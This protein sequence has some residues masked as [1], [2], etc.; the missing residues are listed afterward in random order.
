[1]KM[2]TQVCCV[3]I[4]LYS[5]V[6]S[7][8]ASKAI[9]QIRS[10]GAKQMK[11]KDIHALFSGSKVN[12]IGYG[13]D[14][15]LIFHLNGALSAENERGEKNDGVWGIDGHDN[16]CLKFKRWGG[17]DKICY[18][19]FVLDNEYKFFSNNIKRY[20]AKILSQNFEGA[21]V[22]VNKPVSAGHLQLPYPEDSLPAPGNVQE[23]KTTRAELTPQSK[24]D[25]SHVVR[26]LAKNCPGCNLLKADLAGADL[27]HANL[28]GANLAE[29]DLRQANLRKANLKGANL[30]KADLTGA[31]MSGAELEG[32]NLI[33]AIGLR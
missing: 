32:A 27:S 10:E 12:M 16:L 7:S 1:M 19:V 22:Q 5:V 18:E 6:L 24:Q 30:Y 33:E 21:P 3:L 28:A 15:E 25:I 13:E 2:K 11:S 31:D 17:G 14:A 23:E 9:D 8:C 20:N 26:V 4:I 29:A